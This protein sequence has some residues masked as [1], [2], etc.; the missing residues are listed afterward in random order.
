MK[1]TTTT[2][3]TMSQQS[4]PKFTQND[5]NSHSCFE[6][7]TETQIFRNGYKVPDKVDLTGLPDHVLKPLALGY[8]Q[9]AIMD[10]DKELHPIEFI[11]NYNDVN[12]SL[13]ESD[14]LIYPNIY[15]QNAILIIFIDGYHRFNKKIDPEIIENFMED[16]SDALNE[17]ESKFGLYHTVTDSGIIYVSK[18]HKCEVDGVII[19]LNVHASN[20]PL[21][22]TK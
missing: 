22:N 18:I 8:Y 9:V 12:E 5:A 2:T 20:C 14:E 13:M 11:E 4:T 7:V 21:C 17:W 10:Y 3:A 16:Y 1:I 6:L 19:N 15:K